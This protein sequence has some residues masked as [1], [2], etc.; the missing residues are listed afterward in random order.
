MNF[1]NGP[2]MPN[3][4]MSQGEIRL[5]NCINGETCKKGKPMGLVEIRQLSPP[6]SNLQINFLRSPTR[7]EFLQTWKEKN[8]PNPTKPPNSFL[9]FFICCVCCVLWARE[10]AGIKGKKVRKLYEPKVGLPP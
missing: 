7:K 5:S 4:N 9:L 1:N 2:T 3:G 8:N 6:S 10:K